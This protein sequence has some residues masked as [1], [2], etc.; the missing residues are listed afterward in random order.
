[1]RRMSVAMMAS[2]ALMLLAASCS[3]ERELFVE[4]DPAAPATQSPD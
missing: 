3:D 2:V 1:M 4:L